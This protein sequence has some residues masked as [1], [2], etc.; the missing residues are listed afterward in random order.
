MSDTIQLMQKDD[1]RYEIHVSDI[2]GFLRCRLR[3]KWGSRH[4]ES[5]ET[6]KVQQPLFI[7]TGIHKSLELYYGMGLDPQDVWDKWVDFNLKINEE[8][9]TMFTDENREDIEEKRQLGNDM[10]D[11]YVD[12][13]NE[14]D[15]DWWDEVIAVEESFDV[16][17]YTP[18]GNKSKADLCGRLDMVVKD[19]YGRIWI[20]DHKTGSNIDLNKFR[21]SPQFTAYSY[22]GRIMYGDDFE[23]I[24]P[25]GVEKDVP[26]KPSINKNGSV[27]RRKSSSVPVEAYKK[28]I[29]EQGEDIED[30][31]K[32]LKWLEENEKQFI[33]REKFRKPD[34]ELAQI[35]SMLYNVYTDMNGATVYPNKMDRCSWDCNFNLP[36]E[37]RSRGNEVTNLLRSK[38]KQRESVHRMEERFDEWYLD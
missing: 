16:P 23:G 4:G 11:Y 13:S 38:Y 32:H 31:E 12:Y 5:L 37:E 8:E 26:K 30:Y 10:M 22:A 34:K 1:G 19:K 6:E 2:K 21:F 9:S 28:A 36:C 33:K 24:I 35:N 25:N 15:S 18:K 20:V 27:S 7:G 29:V 14:N 17:I 3:F